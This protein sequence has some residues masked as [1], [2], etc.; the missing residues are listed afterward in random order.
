MD[1]GNLGLWVCGPCDCCGRKAEE[2]RHI[3][4]SYKQRQIRRNKGRPFLF[5]RPLQVFGRLLECEEVE[6]V[7]H[8]GGLRA[9]PS[10]AEGEQ[11]GLKDLVLWRLKEEWNLGIMQL[12]G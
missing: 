6:M 9:S 2:Q 10:L 3:D 11:Q 12:E 1:S 7:D 8:K 5:R 4:E